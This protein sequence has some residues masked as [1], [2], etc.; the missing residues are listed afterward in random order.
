M[1]RVDQ[2]FRRKKGLRP[3][4]SLVCLDS[5]VSVRQVARYGESDENRPAWPPGTVP[6]EAEPFKVDGQVYVLGES[7]NEIE[8][9]G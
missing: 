4:T 1:P 9:L 2:G 3:G 7:V 6:S 5:R 8:A